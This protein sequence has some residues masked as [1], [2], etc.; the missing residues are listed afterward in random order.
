MPKDW[1][2]YKDDIKALYIT[3]GQTLEDVRRSMKEKHGFDASTRSYRMKLDEWGMRK[4]KV[5]KEDRGRK[6]DSRKG[7]PAEGL[8]QVN[9]P[10]LMTSVSG[11]ALPQVVDIVDQLP[12]SYTFQISHPTKSPTTNS[13]SQ[14][15]MVQ[16]NI[17]SISDNLP[18]IQF[19]VTPLV[20]SSLLF[21]SNRT[22]SE[23]LQILVDSSSLTARESALEI[24]LKN[25]KQEG[26]YMNYAKIFL[27]EHGCCSSIMNFVR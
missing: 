11:M 24:L 20:D 26:E 14:P 1:Q 23:S 17:E 10:S 4:N 3:G 19:V 6:V 21:L 16:S 27:R 12:L 25:W 8:L 5:I 22:D 13:L 9:K 7:L 2:I 15:R 18:N